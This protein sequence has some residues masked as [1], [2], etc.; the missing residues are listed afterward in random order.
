MAGHVHQPSE[1][2]NNLEELAQHYHSNRIVVGMPGAD[3]AVELLEMRFS[4]YSI[5]EAAAT[6]AKISNREGLSG[7][8]PSRL[9]YSKEFEPRTRDMFFQSLGNILIA[10]IAIVILSPVMLLIAILVWLTLHGSVL[11]RRVRV[12]KGGT[13]FTLYRFRM[14][15]AAPGSMPSDTFIGRLLSRTGLYALP[16]FFN[17]LAAARCRS[18]DPG[19]KERSS[20]VKLPAIFLF[21]RTGSRFG[22]E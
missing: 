18:P 14:T 12:G 7:L 13:L 17:V 1:P 4:G 2:F 20:S 15:K 19:R 21:I 10:S 16:Q 6:F 11:E 3:L 22:L 9:L 8:G 5:Q